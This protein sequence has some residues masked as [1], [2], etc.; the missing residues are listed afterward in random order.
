MKKAI[1][2]ILMLTVYTLQAQTWQ[3]FTSGNNVSDVLEHDGKTYIATDGGL[4]LYDNLNEAPKFY[5]RANS[6]IPTNNVRFL[7]ITD[8]GV[9]LMTTTKGLCSFQNGEIQRL[10]TD[11]NGPMVKNEAGIWIASNDSLSLYANGTINRIAYHSPYFFYTDILADNE[12]DIWLAYYTF[13]VFG[14]ARWNG[15]E[16]SYWDYNNSDFPFESPVNN[17]LAMDANGKI[18]CL[19]WGGLYEFNGETFVQLASLPLEN[20]WNLGGLE[21]IDNWML[22][23]MSTAFLSQNNEVNVFT[24]NNGEWEATNFWLNDYYT[25]FLTKAG[26]DKYYITSTNLGC[27]FFDFDSFV[28]LNPINSSATAMEN[29]MVSNLAIAPNNQVDFVNGY[30]NNGGT[31]FTLNNNEITEANYPF[32]QQGET[33]LTVDYDKEG[34]LWVLANN[35]YKYNGT[36][37]ETFSNEDIGLVGDFTKG[38]FAFTDNGDVWLDQSVDVF[39]YTNGNWVKHSNLEIGWDYEIQSITVDPSTQYV[40]LVYLFNVLHYDG[41]SWNILDEPQITSITGSNYIYDLDF[42]QAGNMWVLKR[43]SLIR[44]NGGE[45][46]IFD[47]TNS[48]INQS[49]VARSIGINE[50]QVWVGGVDKAALLENNNWQLFD[51]TNLGIANNEIIKIDFDSEAR[52]WFAHQGGGLSLY[53]PDSTGTGF[54]PLLGKPINAMSI[55]PNPVQ[56]GQQFMVDIQDIEKANVKMLLQMFDTKGNLVMQKAFDP[57]NSYCSFQTPSGLSSGLYTITARNKNTIYTGSLVVE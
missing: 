39:Q 30:Y 45:L 36:T 13:G 8:N 15:T 25:P 33:V 31:P 40:Y 32:L 14:V 1:L 49:F 18:H 48:P 56:I 21:Y 37:W 26:H 57:N 43:F 51:N 52:V 9:L 20:V 55:Y 23:G 5:N 11:V 3:N 4:C 53:D 35:I 27:A 44:Y 7:E 24:F 22:S 10:A 41:T 46:E 28:M 50:N 47:E 29:N 6:N 38:D 2:L 42:D 12:G 34:N 54:T 17:Q 19:N 16:W